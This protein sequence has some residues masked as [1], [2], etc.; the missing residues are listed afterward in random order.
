M[1]YKKLLDKINKIKNGEIS[2]SEIQSVRDE[3]DS[4]YYS[5]EFHYSKL[6]ELSKLINE[7]NPNNTTTFDNHNTGLQLLLSY[8]HNDFHETN[9][10][11]YDL[12]MKIERDKITYIT[13]KIDNNELFKEKD[14]KECTYF[15]HSILNNYN[16]AYIVNTLN[17]MIDYI[18]DNIEQ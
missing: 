18:E 9:Y 5:K 14:A 4:L 3:L 15:L 17:Y 16:N 1:V 13:E 10:G 11:N 6:R 2:Y 12:N 7:I 8:Y